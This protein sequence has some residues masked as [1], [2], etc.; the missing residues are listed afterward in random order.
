MEQVMHC[1]RAIAIIS[2]LALPLSAAHAQ[3]RISRAPNGQTTALS[4]LTTRD[5]AEG[6]M[7]KALRGRIVGREFEADNVT[8]N[9]IVLEYSN[10]IRVSVN[11][12]LPAEHLDMASR[13]AEYD[14]LQRLTRPGRLMNGRAIACGAG[15]RV[16]ILEA[17]W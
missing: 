8:L 3:L 14:G 4:G 1:L 10:G 9:G 13:S 15:G 11:V 2:I 17:I 7:H 12:N 6:C 16:S 5:E